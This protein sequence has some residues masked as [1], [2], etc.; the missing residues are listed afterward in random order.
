MQRR[1][2]SEVPIG[3][4]SSPALELPGAGFEARAGVKVNPFVRDGRA[5]KTPQHARSESNPHA[6]TLKQRPAG[7]AL[8]EA[9]CD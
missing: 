4:A 1:E 6:G 2:Q 7:A 9:R 5:L 3:H 8:T